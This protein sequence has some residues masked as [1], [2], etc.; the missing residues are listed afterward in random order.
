MSLAHP[1]GESLFLH[2]SIAPV[3]EPDQG[4][5]TGASPVRAE[6]GVPALPVA[7]H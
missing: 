4:T 5:P 1:D 3:P 7:S 6:L 2:I